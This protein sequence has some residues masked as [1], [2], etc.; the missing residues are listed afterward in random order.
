M[1]QLTNEQRKD[2]I[3][4]YAKLVAQVGIR[5][6]KG[7]EVWVEAGLDQPEFVAMVVEECYECGA[8]SVSVKWNYPPLTKTNFKY[9]TVYSLSKIKSYEKA[10]L[11][12]MV[13]NLPTRLYIDCLFLS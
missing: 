2:R 9:G 6:Q 3:K 5:A 7:E 10:K 11:K 13:K 1:K 8:K 12:Y 4:K